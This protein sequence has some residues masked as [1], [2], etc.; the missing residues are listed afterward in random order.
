MNGTAAAAPPVA[1]G[2]SS[3]G[4]GAPPPI[5]RSKQGCLTCRQRKKKCDETRLPEHNG[6][7]GRCFIASYECEWP[8]P[9][10][11]PLRKF[12]KGAGRPQRPP[13]ERWEA[14]YAY[15]A[16]GGA[17]TMPLFPSAAP[18]APIAGSSAVR[19]SPSTPYQPPPHSLNSSAPALVP[20]PVPSAP[21]SAPSYA[22][23][24]PL[25][26]PSDFSLPSSSLFGAAFDPFSSIPSVMG[27]V[28]FNQFFA[29]L[30]PEFGN[31]VPRSADTPALHSS[32]ANGFGAGAA[33]REAGEGGE[34]EFVL[35]AAAEM[36]GSTETGE[37]V[38]EHLDPLYD[39]YSREYFSSLPKPVRDV[40]CSKIFNAA[41]STVS[42]RSSA[43]AIVMLFRLRQVQSQRNSDDP[44]LAAAAAEQE[45]HLLLAST[46]YFNKALEHL[47]VTDVPLEAKMLAA[48]DLLGFQFERF[49]ASA[50]HGIRLLCESFITE[51]YGPQPLLCFHPMTHIAD[52]AVVCYAWSDI[53]RHL[54]EPKHRPLYSY[55]SLPG[56]SASLTSAAPW[57]PPPSTLQYHR[58]LPFTLL[59]CIAAIGQLEFEKDALPDEMVKLKADYIEKTIRE[60]VPGSPEVN[61]LAD[62]SAYLDKVGSAEMWR[63]ACIIFLHQ[64]IHQHGPLHPVISSSARS[65]LAVGSKLLRSSTAARSILDDASTPGTSTSTPKTPTGQNTNESPSYSFRRDAPWFIAGTVV[66]LPQDRELCRRGLKECGMHYRAYHDDLQALSKI[67]EEQDRRGWAIQ[68]RPYLQHAK[69]RV[70]FM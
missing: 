1:Q 15:A 69:V 29:S 39:E 8:D 14:S 23:A 49:G 32:P 55:P 7:C 3:G 42:N 18:V 51:A 35:V 47:Q 41:S 46:S 11:R 54:H 9:T 65:I 27:D 60:W 31:L 21:S 62:A 34:A 59:L 28:G 40:I 10:Q 33:T 44:A 58:G 4:S 5:R 68:W 25:A 26:F 22:P 52:I 24:P 6:A 57:Q 70:E 63:H 53:L 16:A 36:V 19:P 64:A 17:A 13:S 20:Y 37:G 45:G 50:C 48:Y 43:M 12:E 61:E 2:G 38:V 66:S 30:D 56:D 67:W